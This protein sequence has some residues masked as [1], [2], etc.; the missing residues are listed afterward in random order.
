[1]PS[2]LHSNNVHRSCFAA[3]HVCSCLL[4]KDAASLRSLYLCQRW[5]FGINMASNMCLLALSAAMPVQTW[6][7]NSSPDEF[8]AGGYCSN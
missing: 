1:M 2:Y 5:H 7:C 3:E 4:N 6:P 8:D